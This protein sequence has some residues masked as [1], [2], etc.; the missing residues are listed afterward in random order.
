MSLAD[1]LKANATT[2][3]G[4]TCSVCALLAKLDKADAK[5]LQAALDNDE[6]AATGISRALRAEGYIVGS[7][8]IRRHRKGECVGTRQA[9]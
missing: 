1:S 8:P 5:V 2:V 7:E 4:P 6:F 9:Q 3:K